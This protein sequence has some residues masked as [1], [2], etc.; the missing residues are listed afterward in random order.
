MT[1]I[2]TR[3]R[4][5]FIHIPKCAGTSISSVYSGLSGP[6]DLELGGTP[7]GERIQKAYME[8]YR[9]HKHSTIMQVRKA[10]A[11]YAGAPWFVFSFVREPVE[12]VRSAYRFLKSWLPRSGHPDQSLFRNFSSAEEMFLSGYRADAINRMLYPQ[13]TWLTDGNGKLDVDFVGSVDAAATG[14]AE[15]NRRLG[16]GITADLPQ[17]NRGN[18]NDD[19]RDEQFS[20]TCLD[21]IRDYYR[22]DYET[23][24]F[25]T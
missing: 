22:D 9:L 11:P 24:K 5:V 19:G 12:R 13:V 20:R 25:E 1:I 6:L 8:R 3:Y 21:A 14:I 4:F 23:F 7:F 17:L 15:I 10:L 2:N 18:G 16:I